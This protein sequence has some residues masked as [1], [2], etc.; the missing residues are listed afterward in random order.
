[1]KMK[2][3]V[4]DAYI[5]IDLYE[6]ELIASFF[7]LE[8]EIHTTS[9]VY[10]DLYNEQQQI[11]KAYHSV[12]R[13]ILHN[14]KEEDFIQIYSEPYPRALSETD[15]SVL[16]IANKLNACVLSSDKA[17]RNCAKNKDIECHG[18]IWIFDRLIEANILAKKDAVNK[19]KQFVISNSILQSNK[20]LVDEIQ[21]RLK[22]WQ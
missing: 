20:S 18:M 2:I 1:M 22:S 19:I 8:L 3:A 15:K 17:V 11:L 13:L 5:F 14:L 16:H 7:N 21:K 9:A 6:L 10:N 12:N 4:T